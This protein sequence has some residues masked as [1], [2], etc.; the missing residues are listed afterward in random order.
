MGDEVSR[1][2]VCCFTMAIVFFL[3]GIPVW[4][5]SLDPEYRM[6]LW[7]LIVLGIFLASLLWIAFHKKGGKSSQDIKVK[8]EDEENDRNGPRI[9]E[10]Y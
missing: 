2:Q 1:H 9:G 8:N 10:T 3:I 6:L 5:I 4:I 7:G